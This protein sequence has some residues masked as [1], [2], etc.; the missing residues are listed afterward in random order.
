MHRNSILLAL[1][2]F[3]FELLDGLRV[4]TTGAG[5]LT[6]FL[7]SLAW[8][9]R[10]L[11]GS[12]AHLHWYEPARALIPMGRSSTSASNGVGT[13]ISGP[14]NGVVAEQFCRFCPYPVEGAGS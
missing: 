10:L 8:L 12:A 3:F 5:F 9:R 6:L 14:R 7:E 13:A 11:A 4:R 1:G 2:V